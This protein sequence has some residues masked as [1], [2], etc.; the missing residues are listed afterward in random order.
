VVCGEYSAHHMRELCRTLG[1]TRFVQNSIKAFLYRTG[2]GQLKC[3]VER[4]APGALI[5]GALSIRVVRERPKQT[6]WS[7]REYCQ[8]HIF[9]PNSPD[10]ATFI[11]IR[12]GHGFPCNFAPP[13]NWRALSHKLTE[14]WPNRSCSGCASRLRLNG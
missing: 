3:Q 8:F 1:R 10:E 12:V 14:R 9:A 13:E 11:E 5:N 4:L 7:P 2:T 6:A